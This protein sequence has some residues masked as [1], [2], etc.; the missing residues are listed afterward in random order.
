MS[1][2]DSLILEPRKAAQAPEKM[3]AGLCIF[4]PP[5]CL[6]LFLP[7]LAEDL[8][9]DRDPSSSLSASPHFRPPPTYLPNSSLPQRTGISSGQNGPYFLSQGGLG[10]LD[11]FGLSAGNWP[12]DCAAL[13]LLLWW[14]YESSD[15]PR[16]Q[17]GAGVVGWWGRVG[18]WGGDVSPSLT[19]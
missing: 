11:G 19:L 13:F 18:W 14:Q 16:Q 7:H 6:F 9:R 15:P 3:S 1:D 12:Q 10:P 4:F 17:A 5:A 2:W 8:K